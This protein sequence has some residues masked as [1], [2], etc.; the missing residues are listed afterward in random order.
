MNRRGEIDRA[1]GQARMGPSD[2]AFLRA[3]LR[4]ADN[5]TTEVTD[6]YAASLT[7]LAADAK[8][9][10]RTIQ[11]AAAHTIRHGWWKPAPRTGNTR[12]ITGL[13]MIGYDCDCSAWLA[14]LR[15]NRPLVTARSQARYCSGRCR[16]AARR[17][18]NRHKIAED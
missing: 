11:R 9:S 1:I 14:C 17:D 3:L 16:E 5:E 15:C 10:E 7:R 2:A 18:R 13:I 6:R 8:L 4:R 12:R